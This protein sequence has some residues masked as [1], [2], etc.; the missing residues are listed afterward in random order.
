[1]SPSIRKSWPNQNLSSVTAKQF[2]IFCVIFLMS[3]NVNVFDSHFE[4]PK[5]RTMVHILKTFF[6]TRLRPFL[7]SDRYRP[8]QMSPLDSLVSSLSFFYSPCATNWWSPALLRPPIPVR[9]PGIAKRSFKCSSRVCPTTTSA[10]PRSFASRNG[11]GV[12]GRV[13]YFQKQNMFQIDQK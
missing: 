12:Y 7:V 1:M 5:S 10:R 9:M 6:F 3:G 13:K 2:W 4:N 11:R 8:S